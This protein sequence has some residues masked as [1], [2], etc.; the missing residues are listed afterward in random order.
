MRRRRLKNL[1]STID[2]AV[3]RLVEFHAK[4]DLTRY[5]EPA[6]DW[7]NKTCKVSGIK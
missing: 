3:E 6:R 5:A 1:I 7:G 4:P 2:N